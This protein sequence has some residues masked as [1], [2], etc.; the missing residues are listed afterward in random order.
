MGFFFSAGLIDIKCIWGGGGGV[1]FVGYYKG[2]LGFGNTF[3]HSD[4][5]YIR[6]YRECDFSHQ[7]LGIEF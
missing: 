4:G 6:Y 7:R 1:F 2:F 5:R 3:H